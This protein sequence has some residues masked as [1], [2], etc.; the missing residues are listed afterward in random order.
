MVHDEKP[1]SQPPICQ[2]VAADCMIPLDPPPVD[3]HVPLTEWSYDQ[4][5]FRLVIFAV[6]TA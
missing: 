1:D 5:I 4:H 6:E 2:N 3:A